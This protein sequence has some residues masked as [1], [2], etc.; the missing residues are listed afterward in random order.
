M[1]DWPVT[2]NS[3]A[4]GSLCNSAEYK[5]DFEKLRNAVNALHA[6][7]STLTLS[8]VLTEQVA[9]NTTDWAATGTDAADSTNNQDA[10]FEKKRLIGLWKVPTWAQAFRVR[11]FDVL[12]ATMNREASPPTLDT[13]EGFAIGLSYA[14]ALTDFEPDGSWSATLIKQYSGTQAG[15]VGDWTAA[16]M[17]GYGVMGTDTEGAPSFL[18][19]TGLSSV[20]PAG[21]YIGIWVAG[22]FT[23]P[24]SATARKHILF[25]CTAYLDAMVPIP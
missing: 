4:S 20:V 1:A 12:N 7:F 15:G 24:A 17:Q 11:Q 18:S 9:Y 13:S 23:F 16:N 5:A 21:S 3:Y 19:E 10:T 25:Q 14:D 8:A 2:V 6:R 22:G